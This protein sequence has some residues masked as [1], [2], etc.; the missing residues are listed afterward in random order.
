ML[1]VERDGPPAA[2]EDVLVR[3]E[4]G[5]RCAFALA[6][7]AHHFGPHVGQHHAAEGSGAEACEFDDADAFERT[8][9]KPPGG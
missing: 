8:H 6:V 4:E 7:D 1:E 5:G 9:G 3:V 2:I